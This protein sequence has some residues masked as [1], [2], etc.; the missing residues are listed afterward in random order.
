MKHGHTIKK[1]MWREENGKRIYRIFEF[2]P[3]HPDYEKE[4]ELEKNF[5]NKSSLPASTSELKKL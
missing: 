5:N 4:L 2:K 3:G 1:L